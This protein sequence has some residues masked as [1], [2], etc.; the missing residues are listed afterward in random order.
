MYQTYFLLKTFFSPV[1]R[2]GLALHALN[3]VFVKTK[4]YLLPVK[5]RI[6]NNFSVSIGKWS[7]L[8]FSLE[9]LKERR[10]VSFFMLHAELYVIL[11][12]HL[13]YDKN[14]RKLLHWWRIVFV[15]YRV[16]VNEKTFNT[17]VCQYYCFSETHVEKKCAY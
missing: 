15:V 7:G 16:N 9:K 8:E 4:V 6:R 2:E 1:A 13:R 11:C 17:N 14:D 3:S 10:D 12:E 5:K